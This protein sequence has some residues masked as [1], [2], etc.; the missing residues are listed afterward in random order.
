MLVAV[1]LPF[2]STAQGGDPSTD[3]S[4]DMS[5]GRAICAGP[6]ARASRTYHGAWH[7]QF[8]ARLEAPASRQPFH[9]LGG[10]S[11]IGFGDP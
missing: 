5:D 11:G 7:R 9:F 10:F 2:Q 1:P 6:P 8:Q 4:D 3:I